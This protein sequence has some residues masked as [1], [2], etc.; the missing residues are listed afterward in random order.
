MFFRL[1]AFFTLAIWLGLN[2][3]GSADDDFNTSHVPTIVVIVNQDSGDDV[4]DFGL[5][6]FAA[7]PAVSYLNFREFA[8]ARCVEK[9]P[10]IIAVDR[11]PFEVK[12]SF[13]L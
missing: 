6:S 8:I 7:L 2:V 3:I 13:L 11:R 12:C 4:N 1:V 9:I 10:V 5:L